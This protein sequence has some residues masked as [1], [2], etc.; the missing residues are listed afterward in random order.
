MTRITSLNAPLLAVVASILLAACGGGG[1][2]GGTEPMPPPVQPPPSNE[3]PTSATASTTAYV[4]YTGS[5]LLSDGTE[6]LDVS[7]VTPPTSE[8]EEPLPVS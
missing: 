8:T 3:V 4:Q 7:K 2:G 5:L 1:G 6:P